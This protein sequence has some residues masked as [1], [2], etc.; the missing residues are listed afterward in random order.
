MPLRLGQEV[1]EVPRRR[2]VKNNNPQQRVHQ[3]S[4]NG[5]FFLLRIAPRPGK[6]GAAASAPLLSARAAVQPP[7]AYFDISSSSSP[8]LVAR[9]P[10]PSASPVFSAS[11][12]CFRN[13]RTWLN[14]FFFSSLVA[15][16]NSL[17][18]CST[19]EMWSATCCCCGLE[20]APGESAPSALAAASAV[21]EAEGITADASSPG[22]SV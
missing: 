18:R 16:G 6:I 17:R 1:Q 19:A 9:F 15:A 2:G 14:C 8:A 20:K 12:A 10:A 21:A 22:L 11:T 7:R 3:A 5:A 13:C 4:P